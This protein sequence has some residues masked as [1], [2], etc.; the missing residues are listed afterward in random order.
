MS[1]NRT[2]YTSSGLVAIAA[3]GLTPVL[4][5]SVPAA[6][7]G[8]VFKVVPSIEVDASVPTV[9]SN[10]DV[11]LS[12][13][14]VTGTKAGGAAVTPQQLN[15]NVLAAN[16]VASSGSTAL[17]GLTQSTEKWGRVVPFAAGAFRESDEANTAAEEIPLLPSTNY[18][19]YM[20]VPVGPG[21]GSN[22][23]ARLIAYWA[24]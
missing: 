6:A 14:I 18:A 7:D 22:M 20:R 2:Y 21:A 10:S 11:F 4:Y 24:E 3:T 16:V 9:P 13:N 23:L 8:N 19:F 1:M 12:L 17:T 15:G 5:L